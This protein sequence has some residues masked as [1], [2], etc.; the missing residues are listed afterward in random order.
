MQ[1]AG[2]PQGYGNYPPPGYDGSFQQQGYPSGGDPYQMQQY[3]QE[4]Y[5]QDEDAYAAEQAYYQQQM[6]EANIAEQEKIQ[7]KIDKLEAKQAAKR[8]RDKEKAKEHEKGTERKLARDHEDH[9]SCANLLCMWGMINALMWAAPL[10][11]DNW[12]TKVMHGLGVHKLQI[13]TG[14]FNMVTTVE[15][16][17]GYAKDDR[18]C[19]A[20]EPY[21]G[22]FSIEQMQELMCKEVKEGCE[23]MNTMFYV[24]HVPLC[25]LPAAAALETLSVLLLYVHWHG[26]A[27]RMINSAANNCA[28]LAPCVGGMGFII[29]M[30]F[31]PNMQV[32]PRMWCAAQGHGSFANSALGGLKDVAFTIPFGWCSCMVLFVWIGSACRAF[33]CFASLGEHKVFREELQKKIDQELKEEAKEL[34]SKEVEEARYGATV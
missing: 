11:G 10:I 20:L 32:L 30:G 4:Q 12:Y 9:Q 27:S 6:M 2:A 8:K 22:P 3:P 15:C 26:I 23:L 29:W 17:Q 28:C 25:M 1:Y 31:S 34:V 19:T 5:P 16:I 33:A 21:A 7:R 18:I 24:A 14:L 13:T